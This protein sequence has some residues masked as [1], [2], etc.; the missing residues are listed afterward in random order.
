MMDSSFTL[1]EVCLAD[2]K[3]KTERTLARL[4]ATSSA[5][6]TPPRS[7]EPAVPV[8]RPRATAGG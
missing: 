7:H 5:A 3:A 6:P 1:A 4:R 2:A 8:A